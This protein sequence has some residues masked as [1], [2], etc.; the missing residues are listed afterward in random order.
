MTRTFK[1]VVAPIERVVMKEAMRIAREPN[2]FFEK[3]LELSDRI[4]FAQLSEAVFCEAYYCHFR[5]LALRNNTRPL[6][7]G[8]IFLNKLEGMIQALVAASEKPLVEIFTR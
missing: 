8:Q 5:N 4:S 7:R 1:E 3:L 6:P 2:R